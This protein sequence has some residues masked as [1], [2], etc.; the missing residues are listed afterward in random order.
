MSTPSLA[1]PDVSRARLAF[2]Y[3]AMTALGCAAGLALIR[4]LQPYPRIDGTAT[5]AV[6]LGVLFGAPVG[7]LQWGVLHRHARSV[8]GASGGDRAQAG[9]RIVRETAWWIVWTMAGSAVG[10]SLVVLQLHVLPFPRF[11]LRAFATSGLILGVSFGLAQERL[12][13]RHPAGRN[14]WLG[15]TVAG[16]VISHLLTLPV[17]LSL[18]D[19]VWQHLAYNVLFGIPFGAAQAVALYRLEPAWR[20]RL[21]DAVRAAS[22]DPLDAG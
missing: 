19:T 11:S 8:L 3:A 4:F 21:S 6:Q 15:W 20:R 9:L 14:G 18:S 5:S 2:L 7:L 13:I 22:P 1:S 10:W 12:L 17:G 16:Q